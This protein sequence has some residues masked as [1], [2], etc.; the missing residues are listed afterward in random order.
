[1]VMLVKMF[2]QLLGYWCGVGKMLD[3][4]VKMLCAR[5]VLWCC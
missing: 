5:H 3:T 2:G 4:G 1:M